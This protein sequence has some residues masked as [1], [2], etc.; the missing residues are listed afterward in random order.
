MENSQERLL[1]YL[2]DAWAI[3]KA[4]VGSLKDMAD[5][6]EDPRVSALFL[7]HAQVTHDQEERLEARIRALGSDVNRA[8]GVVNTVLGKMSE[9]ANMFH[10]E[11]D[12]TTQNLIKGFAT[13][14]FETGMYEALRAYASAIG[15]TETATLAQE[16]MQQEKEAA[17]KVWA[18]I[19]SAAVRPLE[20]TTVSE[21][22]LA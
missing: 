19:A 10:D 7:E 6:T 3:E 21:P 1:R 16:L 13:E 12:K 14:N 20:N 17:Q 2:E 11:E 9:L 22:V 18:L 5:A 4:L 15:D 8:K